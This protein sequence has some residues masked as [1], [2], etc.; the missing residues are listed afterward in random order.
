MTLWTGY[1][2]ED[3]EEC[4]WILIELISQWKP[5]LMKIRTLM[6]MPL[7]IFQLFFKFSVTCRN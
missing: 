3:L 6:K 5:S 7:Q 2:A 1:L 4:G